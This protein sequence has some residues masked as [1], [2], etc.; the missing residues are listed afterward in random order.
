MSGRQPYAWYSKR[1]RFPLPQDYECARRLYALA[2][3]VW[4]GHAVRARWLLTGEPMAVP[5]AA[6]TLAVLDPARALAAVRDF[7]VAWSIVA[8]NDGKDGAEQDQAWAALGAALKPLATLREAGGRPAARVEAQYLFALFIEV[9]TRMGGGTVLAP[10]SNHRW[11]F[12]ALIE[13]SSSRYDWLDSGTCACT[14]PAAVALLRDVAAAG[15]VPAQLCLAAYHLDA[16]T[17]VAPSGPDVDHAGQAVAWLLRAGTSAALVR[18]SEVSLVH[19]HVATALGGLE[20][21]VQL[22]DADGA[23]LVPLALWLFPDDMRIDTAASRTA[24]D[25]AVALLQRAA[26]AGDIAAALLLGRLSETYNDVVA[27][28]LITAHRWY[29]KVWASTRP[30][31]STWRRQVARGDPTYVALSRL[32]EA[33]FPRFWSGPT[34]QIVNTQDNALDPQLEAAPVRERWHSVVDR[35]SGLVTDS[36]RVPDADADMDMD[37]VTWAALVRAADAGHPRAM[38]RLLVVPDA[39]LAHVLAHV[40][41]AAPAAPTAVAAARRRQWRLKLAQAGVVSADDSDERAFKLAMATMVT[42]EDADTHRAEC[43]RDGLLGPPDADRIESILGTVAIATGHP[44]A[45]ASLAQLYIADDRPGQ[46]DPAATTLVV[47]L[48]AATGHAA[49]RGWVPWL[50]ERG[51]GVQARPTAAKTLYT[52]VL[53]LGGLDER[54]NVAANLARM[55]AMDKGADFERALRLYAVAERHL[56]LRLRLR[57]EDG[58]GED[59]GDD[60]TDDDGKR[61]RC[62]FPA[63]AAAL[64][65]GTDGVVRDPEH[66]AALAGLAAHVTQETEM[67]QQASSESFARLPTELL[68]RILAHLTPADLVA[69]RRVSRAWRA[70][71]GLLAAADRRH[72]YACAPVLPAPQEWLEDSD[73]WVEVALG[74]VPCSCGALLPSPCRAARQLAPS[75]D[76]DYTSVHA[77]QLPPTLWRMAARHRATAQA[78]LAILRP[79]DGM[80]L[81]ESVPRLGVRELTTY[82]QRLSISG[83]VYPMKW[84]AGHL[85]LPPRLP[86]PSNTLQMRELVHAVLFSSATPQA[87]ERSSWWDLAAGQHTLMAP[88]ARQNVPD[89]P[90]QFSPFLSEGAPGDLADPRHPVWALPARWGAANAAAHEPAVWYAPYQRE[91]ARAGADAR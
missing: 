57:L 37:P 90:S 26:S 58:G 74:P 36:V 13:L 48:A 14:S 87:E 17:A 82:R 69:C 44:R 19:G 75:A 78:L 60:D 54:A 46:R 4:H 25:R 83:Q 70:T 10:P 32:M 51:H 24:A 79:V 88:W 63:L 16:L 73:D 56:R 12:L 33:G 52:Y 61:A 43:L 18:A 41:E 67:A 29:A 11:L 42:K 1:T 34:P 6:E 38:Q 68:E 30:D 31:S 50:L 35:L 23:A 81:R 86:Q 84:R 76:V 80:V 15:H 20:R 77:G 59:R 28:D 27:A 7:V 5:L 39:L 21:A 2:G 91:R 53:A 62:M 47:H 71:V 45:C 55:V 3:P 65:S 22:P 66:A 40:A 64:A 85:A 8:I 89:G 72:R 9:S 49:A